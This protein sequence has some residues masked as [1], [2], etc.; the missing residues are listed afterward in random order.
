MRKKTYIIKN[1]FRFT[2]FLSILA[3]ILIVILSNILKM[4]VKASESIHVK[5]VQ[6]ASGD[7]LWSI[8]SK[9]KLENEDIRNYILK[10]RKLNNLKD[11]NLKV[12]SIIKLPRLD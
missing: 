9:E 11:P 4:N 5:E 3:L 10:I 2:V 7:T 8:A 12:G 6:I 1:Y